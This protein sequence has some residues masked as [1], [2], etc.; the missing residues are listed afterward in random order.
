MY[1]IVLLLAL[2]LVSGC[3]TRTEVENYTITMVDTTEQVI[4]KS[5]PDRRD[6]GIVG[7]SS[8]EIRV[9]RKVVQFDSTVERY[10]PD[11]IRLGVFESA[12][13][14]TTMPADR[15]PAVMGLFGFARLF[16]ATADEDTNV[17]FS[18][19]LYRFGVGEWRLQWFRDAKN[20]TI[21][22]YITE[23]LV[24][25]RVEADDELL[26]GVLPLY[27]RKRFFL[28][29]EIPYIALTPTFGIGLL[30]SLYVHIGGSADVGSIGGLN[31][32]AYLGYWYGL[33]AGEQVVLVAPD[34]RINTVSTLY[35]GLGISFL[36]FLNRE[37]EM[38]IE[39]KDHPHSAWD[40][41]AMQIGLIYDGVDST[42]VPRRPAL[43]FT[44]FPVQLAIPIMPQHFHL[45][46]G[47]AL[48]R[49][50]R[51]A[52][53]NA[54]AFLPLRFGY[55]YT[56]LPDELSIFPF[57]E[58]GF[59]PFLLTDLGVSLN[60]YVNPYLNVRLVGGYYQSKPNAEQLTS[61]FLGA[62]SIGRWYAS[63]VFGIGDRIFFDHLLRYAR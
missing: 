16:D 51:F 12:G 11:F 9:V 40:V 50:V 45:S 31:L 49:Y 1:A 41:G 32:R 57:F 30:P 59:Y 53:T 39:W 34:R 26:W 46:V 60:L 37:A 38:F 13:L 21:G 47:T 36:D 3:I 7:P 56:L 35:F 55:W 22:T 20:W 27:L 17:V 8:R 62:H 33:S 54:L 18:G 15:Q 24:P 2:T 61:E 52:E 23:M 5:A 4:M 58:V 29:E 14:I 25:H 6:R 10:Y 44:I 19:G 42:G 28:R 48:L 43:S 63:I